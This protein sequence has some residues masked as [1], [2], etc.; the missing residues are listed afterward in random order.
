V[1]CIIAASQSFRETFHPAEVG[2]LSEE[3]SHTSPEAYQAGI[4]AL[5]ERDYRSKG[6]GMALIFIV[7]EVS[8]FKALLGDQNAAPI[9]RGA[10]RPAPTSE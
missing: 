10:T 2:K 6:L 1:A 8:S 7:S 3:G 5:A 9:N 4:S